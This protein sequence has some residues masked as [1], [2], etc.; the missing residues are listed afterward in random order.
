MQVVPTGQT[1]A[2]QSTR[3]RSPR[4]LTSSGV[5]SAAC[6]W[7][8]S[9]RSVDRAQPYV[10]SAARGADR[11]RRPDRSFTGNFQKVQNF[12]I[13]LFLYGLYGLVCS[14]PNC[15]EARAKSSPS[16]AMHE[17]AAGG[18]AS[19]SAARYTYVAPA[20][21]ARSAYCIAAAAAGGDP[22]TRRRARARTI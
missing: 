16:P 4:P 18:S 2:Q 10:E 15:G 20:C 14:G 17:H 11:A 1:H 3:L 19:E 8:L 9:G 12:N 13:F 5:R 6:W 22:P 21:G 7:L